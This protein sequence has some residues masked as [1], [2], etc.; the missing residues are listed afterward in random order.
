MSR[1]IE[2]K[3][4]ELRHRVETLELHNKVLKRSIHLLKA[5]LR[6]ESVGQARTPAQL[7]REERANREESRTASV[8]ANTA[9]RRNRVNR[10]TAALDEYARARKDIFL[11]KH[12]RILELGQWVYIVTKGAHT[13]R[14]RRGR[15]SG[16][17]THRN[18]VYVLD[19]VGV[20]QE[21][22]PKNL[23]IER[24]QQDD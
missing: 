4:K 15:V 23:K 1:N 6:G 5:Q 22:A 10:A 24:K 2:D 19:E 20:T 12:G 17:D 3:L 9:I 16:F 7:E 13:N 18:R 8:T 11:D 14:S 21:R